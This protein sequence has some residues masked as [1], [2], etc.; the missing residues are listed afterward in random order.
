MIFWGADAKTDEPLSGLVHDIFSQPQDYSV[1]CSSQCS[2]HANFK[3][4]LLNLSGSDILSIKNLAVHIK[5]NCT[6]RL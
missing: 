3:F 6:H 4:L 5:Y 2:I 1:L